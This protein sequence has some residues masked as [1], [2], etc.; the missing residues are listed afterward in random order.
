LTEAGISTFVR[1]FQNGHLQPHLK[2][3]PVP[4]SQV[5]PVLQIVGKTFDSIVMDPSK[6][7]LVNFYA[8]WCGHCK[9]LEPVYR[10]LA[11][12]VEG[13]STLVIARI[14]ATANDVAD[15]DVEGFP[16][17]KLWRAG[18]KEERLDYDADRDVDSFVAWLDS[19]VTHPFN[20]EELPKTEL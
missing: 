11:K 5:G 16:T 6:D 2:S 10:D 13:V 14:D 4:A 3:E 9:K 18:N 20:R 7:V 19:K 8:P 1:D 15:M 12:K 17:I